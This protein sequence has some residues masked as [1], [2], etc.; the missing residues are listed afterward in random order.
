[1]SKNKVTFGLE[2]VHIAFLDDSGASPV[3]EAPIHVPG[4]ISFAPEP[5]GE[6]SNFFADN[7]PYFT[8]TSN[9]GYSGDLSTAL[10]SDAIQA[11]MLGWSIDDNGMLV[12]ETDGVPEEFALMGQIQGDKKN[13]RFV[14][15]RCK[16]SRPSKEYATKGESVEPNPDNLTLRILPVEVNGVNIVKSVLELNDANT[17]VYDAFFD[18]VVVPEP[19]VVDKTE[20]AAVIALAGTLDQLDYTV[21]SWTA[22]STALA[23][24][25]IVNDDV[26]ATQNEVN[27]N[28]ATLTKAI[29][30]LVPDET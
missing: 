25:D 5:Q 22:F 21:A 20:L 12:E 29:L 28:Q 23:T 14:Y 24:A 3:W 8:H 15:Y 10:I 16:A 7:M 1:M 30:A 6:E 19:A 4:A 11:R 18:A 27:E 2:K 13:R 17:A 9:N 26:D